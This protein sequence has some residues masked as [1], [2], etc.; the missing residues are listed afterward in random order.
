MRINKQIAAHL[1]KKV[2][3]DL[4]VS[5][6]EGGKF[7]PE[8]Q[9]AVAPFPFVSHELAGDIRLPSKPPHSALEFR[10]SHYLML[11]QLC[12]KCQAQQ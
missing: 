1:S 8:V 7:G 10:A 2:P 5:I 11:G 4:L 12:P 3:S 9:T 6:L